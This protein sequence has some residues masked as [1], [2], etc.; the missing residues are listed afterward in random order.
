LLRE[1]ILSQT[2]RR[3]ER[4]FLTNLSDLGRPLVQ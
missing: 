3:Q 2:A 4:S 1:T